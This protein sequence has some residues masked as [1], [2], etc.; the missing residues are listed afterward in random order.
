MASAA[1]SNTVEVTSPEHF[2]Q[3]L[4]VDLQRIS[5]I[6]FWAP[7]AEPCKQMNEVVLELAKRHP[8]LLVLNVDAESQAD[9]SESFEIEAVPSF[10][11]LQGHTLLGKIAGADATALTEAISKHVRTPSSVNP[12][13]HTDLAPAAAPDVAEKTESQEELARR[14]HALMQQSKVVLFMK[15]SPDAPRCGFS[16]R[17]VGLLKDQGVE[18]SHFD[19]LSDESVRAGLKVLNDWPTFPQLIVS[20]EFVGGLDI[21]QEMVENGE[22]KEI[23]E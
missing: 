9:I 4:A 6:N 23:L 11:I 7:W 19:I 16:R 8:Q 17:I 5:L 18:F 1:A 22:L 3:Q 20:G 10:I 21:V 15:G 12:Q 13:S 2:Q 14:L